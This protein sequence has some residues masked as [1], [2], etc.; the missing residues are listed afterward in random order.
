[1]GRPGQPADFSPERDPTPSRILPREDG[2]DQAEERLSSHD[3][4]LS[5][6]I[7]TTL[8]CSRSMTTSCFG[9]KYS[10][11]SGMTSGEVDHQVEEAAMHRKVRN[12]GAPDLVGPF[13][14]HA[15]QQVRIDLVAWRRPTQIGF[16]IKSF[17]SQN[18]HQPLNA[19]AADLQRH[20]HATTAEERT[21]QVQLVESP[22]QT[23]VLRALR[24]R[25]IVVGRARHTEQVALPFHAQTGMLRID[26]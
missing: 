17:D 12:I 22:Q 14:R 4:V 7:F 1:M 9:K 5:S 6:S 24:P 20:G 26:P 23:Q 2:R 3:G 21:I 10:S 25:L 16:R 11:A 18:P 19:L 15:T 13:D 8:R